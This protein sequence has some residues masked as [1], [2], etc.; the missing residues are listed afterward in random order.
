[1]H[2][3]RAGARLAQPGEFTMR[4]FL[5]GASVGTPWRTVALTTDARTLALPGRL[6][7]LQARKASQA[8]LH[9]LEFDC[10]SSLRRRRACRLS[11]LRKLQRLL[12]ARWPRCEVC[13]DVRKRI[14]QGGGWALSRGVRVAPPPRQPQQVG[15]ARA[16]IVRGP[17]RRVGSAVR[18]GEVVPAAVVHH[19]PDRVTCAGST[20][21]TTCRR[22]TT[23]P[24]LPGARFPLSL[25]AC[26]ADAVA[27][28]AAL[29]GRSAAQLRLE[30]SDILQGAR[31]G[32]LLATGVQVG[33][34]CWCCCHV[35]V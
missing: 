11:S 32:C 17:H 35:D 24:S 19:T 6:D 27:A 30:V 10:L 22:S 2:T 18:P 21:M 26:G 23:A 14:L 13:C 4:A 29:G 12:T 9:G 16:H 3:Q 8:P 5:N 7:L 20:L 33:V 31:R 1:M 15:G 25:H 34:M 28:A